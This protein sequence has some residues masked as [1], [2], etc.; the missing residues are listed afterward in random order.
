MVW[1]ETEWVEPRERRRGIIAATVLFVVLGIGGAL[2]TFGVFMITSGTSGI[3]LAV[4]GLAVLIAVALSANAIHPYRR[5]SA[6]EAGVTVF[7]M[8]PAAWNIGDQVVLETSHCRKKQALAEHWRPRVARVVYFFPQRPTQRYARG[9]S[10]AG[11]HRRPRHLY[12]LEL[13]HPIDPVYMR[14]SARA[15]P[16]D[17][18]VIVRAKHSLEGVWRKGRS[19]RAKAIR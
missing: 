18:T 10:L 9:Q 2:Y 11:R 5:T 1:A 13:Q 8:S 16:T 3:V 17:V 15:T 19:T 6:V 12:E 7:H 14:S 4:A